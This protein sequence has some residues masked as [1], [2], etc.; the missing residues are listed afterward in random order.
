MSEYEQQEPERQPTLAEQLSQN[1]GQRVSQRADGSIDVLASIGGVRGV[2]EAI[3]PGFIFVLVFAFSSELSW[4][5]IASIAVGA[6][7][8]VLRLLGKS[9][10]MQAAVG[11]VGILI[12]AFAAR[13]TGEAKDYYVPGFYMGAAYLVALLISIFVRW[14]LVGVLFGFIRNEG[15]RW[16][17]DPSRV[18]RYQLATWVLA[19]VFILRLAVQLPMYFAD[20]VVALG[21][22]RALM[23][24]PLY[25]AGLYLGWMISKP[26]P[27]PLQ[28]EAGPAK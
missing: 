13:T 14:P 23:G 25:A 1:A 22:S 19:G 9:T 3:L 2:L 11:M 5:L 24:V 28:G 16:R 20:E 21:I 12:C 10:V 6:V 7:F 8:M 26:A 27:Q 4:A 15:V 18:R 17:E